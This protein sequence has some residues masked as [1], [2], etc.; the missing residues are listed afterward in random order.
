M[1]NLFAL[2]TEDI[3]V[4]GDILGIVFINARDKM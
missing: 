2:A 4:P 1:S 3:A